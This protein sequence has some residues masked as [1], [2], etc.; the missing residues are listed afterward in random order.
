MSLYSFDREVEDLTDAPTRKRKRIDMNEQRTSIALRR[1]SAQTF[2]KRWRQILQDG[3]NAL[4][5]GA[6]SYLNATPL[7]IL[8]HAAVAPGSPASC[9]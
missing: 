8:W 4:R 7:G 1:S 2:E 6:L 9:R 5:R 3:R